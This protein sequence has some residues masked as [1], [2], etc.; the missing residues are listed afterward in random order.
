MADSHAPSGFSPGGVPGRGANYASACYPGAAVAGVL[1]GQIVGTV[2]ASCVGTMTSFLFPLRASF[3]SARPLA[4]S[5]ALA[6]SLVA[7]SQAA[8]E[9]NASSTANDEAPAAPTEGI[10][11]PEQRQAFLSKITGLKEGDSYALHLW[12]P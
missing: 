3:S 6:V 4:A 12:D 1:T 9:S 11:T 10:L 2:L 7:C 8:S 5:L